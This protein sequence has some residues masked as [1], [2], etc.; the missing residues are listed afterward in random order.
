MPSVRNLITAWDIALRLPVRFD[1]ARLVRDVQQMDPAW[2]DVHRGPYHDGKWDV[3][4][5]RAPGGDAANQTSRG[6]AF[7][8]T[9]AAGRCS[10]L[11]EVVAS[12]PGD[13]NRVRY[14]RLRAGGHIQRHSDPI[15]NIDPRLIRI[16]VPVVTN[17]AVRFV[18]AGSVISMAAGEAWYVDIRFPHEVVNGGTTDRV[19]LV[20]DVLRN[21][22][23]SRM[24]ESGASAGKGYLTTYFLKH[25]LPRRVQRWAGIGN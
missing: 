15:E 11:R 3:I 22:E 8:D 12:F 4:A 5:L 16:H 10:Y 2:W 6:G 13:L 25:A 19:H 9:E 20:I 24:V 7:A 21:P 1:A 14:M 17:P 18:V 23:I